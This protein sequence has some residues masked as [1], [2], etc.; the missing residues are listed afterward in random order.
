MSKMGNYERLGSLIKQ[1]L[2]ILPPGSGYIA[3]TF[4]RLNN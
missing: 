1:S 4:D 2:D 3:G